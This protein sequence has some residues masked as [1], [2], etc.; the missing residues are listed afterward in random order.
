MYTFA[1]EQNVHKTKIGANKVVIATLPDVFLNMLQLL[2]SKHDSFSK[3]SVI[4]WELRL[5]DVTRS[6]EETRHLF[7]DIVQDAHQ[8]ISAKTYTY[9]FKLMQLYRESNIALR[10]EENVSN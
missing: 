10:N 4:N 9:Y 5:N 6:D 7:A 1:K 8:V 3:R 2:R